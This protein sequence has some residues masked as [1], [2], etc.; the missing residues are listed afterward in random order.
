MNKQWNKDGLTRKKL[1]DNL[2]IHEPFHALENDFSNLLARAVQQSG[3]LYHYQPL[4]ILNEIQ[5]MDTF[6]IEQDLSQITLLRNTLYQ[7]FKDWYQRLNHEASESSNSSLYYDMEKYSQVLDEMIL[8]DP[9]TIRRTFYILLRF[10]RNLQGKYPVYLQE[11]SQS[12]DVDPSFALLIAFLKN[13]QYLVKQFNS[14]WESYP[15]F[16]ARKILKVNPQ[17]AIIPT[18]WFVAVKNND[19]QWV[20]IPKGTDIISQ[21]PSSPQQLLFRY[22]TDEDYFVNDMEITQIRSISLEK[23]IEKYPASKLGFVTSVWQ[24]QLSDRIGEVP[25]K[26]PNQDSEVIFENQQSVQAGLRIESPMFLLREG[27]RTVCVTFGLSDESI[28]YFEQLTALAEQSSYE[29]GRILNDAFSL[30]MS[31]EKGWSPVPGYTLKFVGGNAFQLKFILDEKFGSTTPTS[32]SHGYQSRYPVLSILMNPDAWLFPYSWASRIYITSLQIKV[33]VTG[34]SSLKIHNPLGELD[35]SVH[36]PLLGVTPQRGAWFAFGNYEMAI[37]PIERLALSLRWTELPYTEEGFYDLYRGYQLPIDNTSFQIEWEKLAD[38]KWVKIP[39]TASCLFATERGHTSPREKLSNQSEVICDK[40]LKNPLVYTDE[41]RYQF[42]TAHQGF[43]R[44]VLNKPD[45]GFGHQEYRELFAHIMIQNSH[46][47]KP[48]PLPSSPYTPMI[49]GISV[50][51]RAEEEYYFNGNDL[52]GRCRITHISPLTELKSQEVNLRHP[53]PIAEVPQENGTILFGIGN[54]TGNDRIRLFFEMA[55]LKRE[56]EKEYLPCVRWAYSNGKRW[57]FIRPDDLLCD[58]TGNL[59]NTGLV[60]ILLPQ[61]INRESLDEHGIF[62]V[63]AKVSCHTGNCSS[64]RNAYL[65][66]IKAR[67]EIPEEQEMLIGETLENFTGPVSFEK[68]QNGLT[69]IYQIIPAKGGRAPET[70][71]DMQLRCTQQIAHRNRAILPADYEQMVLAEFPEVE[72]VLCLPGIE[73]K[74]RNRKAV[75]TLAVMQKETNKQ[76]L[77]LCE[78]RLLVE[79]EEFLKQ[80]TSPFVIVDAISPV[81]E[82]VTVCCSLLVKSG[83]PLGEILRQTET[84]INACIAPWWEKGEM[85]VFGHSFSST[86]LYSSIREDEAIMDLEKLSVAHIVYTQ[87][88]QQRSYHLNRYPELSK[89]DFNVAPSQP[90]CILVPPDKHLIY[91]NQQG[92]LLDQPGVGDLGIG[93]NFI[94]NR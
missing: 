29:M 9:Q 33:S 38:R 31:T 18:A 52:Q 58:T 92:S 48:L 60:D 84:R 11:L 19:I 75:V 44:I 20:R 76:A 53:F 7:R 93:G 43:F 77:P 62:W 22:R 78:H 91:I 14:R 83:Y 41:D 42:S 66:P 89:K 23:D 37:K 67:L 74:A 69:D 90:W 55:P 61:P 50:S 3:S 1:E 27:Q 81:Y 26:C 72:K 25:G 30:E 65:N 82:T 59:L 12:G 51:Y 63:S 16:Y 36:I 2:R 45:M 40:P 39:D 8:S 88:D 80:R 85:P 21:V 6:A 32:E 49:E 54:A 70:S 46:T 94:I 87:L 34:I 15:A 10:I 47:R 4:A 13:Y 79:I 86:D 68:S 17:K 64:I 56:I 28:D 71:E 73:S 24:K 57:E 5:Q 35:T